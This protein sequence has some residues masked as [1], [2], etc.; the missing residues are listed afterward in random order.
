MPA[1]IFDCD[2]VLADTEMHGHLPAFNQAF[3]EHGVPV[4]WDPQEYGRKVRIGGGKERMRSEFTPELAA[5]WAGYP[6]DARA[7]EDLIASLHRRKTEVY[8]QLIDEGR[9]APR[10]GVAELAGEA[11]AAGWR[12]AVA[13]TSAEASVRAVLRHTVGDVLAARFAVFA[14]DIVPRK[15]PAPDIYRHAMRELAVLPE[16]AVVIEDSEIGLRAAHAAG[17][18]TIVT[19]ST[20][21]ADEDFVGAARVLPDLAG[22]ALADIDEVR[23]GSA[24]APGGRRMSAS[25]ETTRFVVA[26]IAATVV[27]NED[28]FGELDAVVG[29][30]DFGFS[31]ARGFEKV[32]AELEDYPSDSAA[33]V[34]RATALTISRRVGGTSG[35]IWGTGFLRAAQVAVGVETLEPATVVAML[36][37][38]TAGIQERGKAELGDKTLLDALVPATDALEAAALEGID[39]PRLVARF[40]AAMRAAAEQT[41]DLQAMRGRASYS[42]IR[43]VGSP[44]AGAVALAVLAERLAER[45][46]TRPSA[47]RRA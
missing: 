16:D 5:R 39:T 25:A 3:R 24:G 10:P 43:S 33:A 34:L 9:I 30:G 36:R 40:A 27:E 22:I 35:P 1:L 7:L 6:T 17:I 37:A 32:Q 31:L 47:G 46:S 29:D 20:Y 18:A 21:T 42:G 14:G 15:K 26:T 28:Y 13:S 44:D 8:T 23:I 19:I 4:Q 2:G 45:W 41:R 38:A 11:D 12:L